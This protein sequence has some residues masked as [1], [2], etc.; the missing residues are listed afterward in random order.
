[1]RPWRFVLCLLVL[2]VLRA[3]IAAPGDHPGIAVRINGQEISYERFNA[4]YQEYLRQQHVNIVLTG[5]PAKLTRMRREAMDRMVEQE[6]VRQAAQA[7]A[8]EVRTEEVDGVLDELRSQFKD[9]EAFI[10]RLE[11]ESYTL[12][13]YRERLRGMLAAGRYLDQIR[14][15]VASVTDEELETYYRANE[16]RLTLPEEVRVRHILLTWKPLGTTDD[17]ATLRRQMQ[18]ILEQA[19]AGA[20][21]AEL[22]RERSEDSTSGYGGDTGFFHRGQMVPAFE[23]VAFALQPGE[24]S[25]IVETPF[26]LHILRLEERREARL[27]PL[28]EVREQLR[29]YLRQQRMAAAVQQEIERLKAQA[30]IQELIPL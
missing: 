8:V 10:R 23:E 22:A 4:F 12:E 6:L 7:Q 2:G 24:I 29:D 30:E 28:Q 21:F 14:A 16:Y 3:G 19:R 26:G 20:D 9:Q 18:G 1:M 15:G 27:L 5:N 11:S 25:D 13:G 17:R